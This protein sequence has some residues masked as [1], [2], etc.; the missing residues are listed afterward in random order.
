LARVAKYYC[1]SYPCIEDDYRY[2]FIDRTGKEIIPLQ[3]SYCNDFENGK[4]IAWR[5]KQCGI[6]D[7]NGNTLLPF[8]YTNISMNAKGA[9]ISSGE[10]Y[11]R[12]YGIIDSACH[13]TVPVKFKNI[14]HYSDNLF[15]LFSDDKILVTDISGKVMITLSLVH[16]YPVCENGFL[17]LT[18][19]SYHPQQLLI[20]QDDKFVFREYDYIS[21]FKFDSVALVERDSKKGLIDRKGNYLVPLIDV[22]EIEFPKDGIAIIKKN[23]EFG[24]ADSTGIIVPCGKYQEMN[25]FCGDMSLVTSQT[26]LYGYIDRNGTEVI[27]CIYYKANNFSEGYATVA[28]EITKSFF[29]DK[30]G[31]K[32]ENRNWFLKIYRSVF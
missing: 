6:I 22:D 18:L 9:I 10:N 7:R 2:G 11:Y 5:G 12:Y 4:A 3:Y 31:D 17:Y 29:I 1:P 26:V 21:I 23:N 25:E 14:Q 32:L 30:N 28:K 24:L 13:I 8:N 27:P 15:L 16:Y 20:R 19:G